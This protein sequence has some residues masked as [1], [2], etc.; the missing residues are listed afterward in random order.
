MK[1]L[2]TNKWGSFSHAFTAPQSGMYCVKARLASGSESLGETDIEVEEYK[3]PKFSVELEKP[4]GTLAL[5]VPVNIKG[6]ATTYSGL[7]VTNAKVVWH[8]ECSMFYPKWWS[9]VTGEYE[10]EH[11]DYIKGEV[12]TEENGVFNLF[13]G[14]RCLL[15]I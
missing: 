8:V 6:R 13:P 12:V 1:T 15:I 7:P 3:R 9:S 5:G 4:R 14:V 2:K 11:Y 10:D